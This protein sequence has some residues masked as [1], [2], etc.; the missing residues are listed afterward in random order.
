MYY[1]DQNSLTSFEP[2]DLWNLWSLFLQGGYGKP[3]KEEAEIHHQYSL[4]AILETLNLPIERRGEVR[5][6]RSS[7]QSWKK[8]LFEKHHLTP[9]DYY[10]TLKAQDG[11]CYLCNRNIQ[12]F[13]WHQRF[14]FFI[15]GTKDKTLLCPACNLLISH[16]RQHS[17]PTS[18]IARIKGLF[19]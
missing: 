5:K 15:A 9:K 1:L 14:L 7:H 4:P 2:E 19:D 16:L 17:N 11:N 8:R 12:T 13:K 10:K 3:L 18:F 6:R